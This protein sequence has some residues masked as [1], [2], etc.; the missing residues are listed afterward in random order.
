MLANP[1]LLL[2]LAF[3]LIAFGAYVGRRRPGGR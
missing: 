2:L 3:A 1:L